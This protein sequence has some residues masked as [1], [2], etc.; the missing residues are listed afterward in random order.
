MDM[1]RMGYTLL[2]IAVG[3]G[4]LIEMG[5][6]RRRQR[7]LLREGIDKV[8]ERHFGAMVLLHTSVLAG[9]AL[10]VWL[11]KRPFVRLLALPMALLFLLANVLRWWV[12]ATLA[13]HWNVQVMNSIGRGVVTHGPY[14]W[15]RHP[16]Y[17]AVFLELLALPLIHSAWLTALLGSLAHSWV[18]WQR[19]STE[20]DVLMAHPAYRQAMGSKPRFLPR[21]SDG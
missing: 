9:A 2:L 7:T 16:N 4:R 19:I 1:K 17:V 13:E 8:P 12:I 18:L 20:E 11:L 15:I 5:V 21:W 14:R 3:L 6:S 10:E